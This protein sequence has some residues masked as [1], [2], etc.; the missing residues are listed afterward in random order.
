L[1]NKTGGRWPPGA[2]PD[3]GNFVGRGRDE[4]VGGDALSITVSKEREEGTEWREKKTMETKSMG[5]HEDRNKKE[6]GGR[7]TTEDFAGQKG[8]EAG[9]GNKGTN[10]AS[11]QVN[12]CFS[13]GPNSWRITI[14]RKHQRGK[15]GEKKNNGYGGNVRI[16]LN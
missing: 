10:F 2:D 12:A 8:G 14:K 6:E 4:N 7:I 3:D 15:R 13:W 1:G 9:K 11:A 16:L 5:C